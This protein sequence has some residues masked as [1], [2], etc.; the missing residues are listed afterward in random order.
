MAVAFCPLRATFRALAALCPLQE[1]GGLELAPL[2]GEGDALCPLSRLC[3]VTGR[4]R[5]VTGSITCAL[6]HLVLHVTC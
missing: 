3:G 4:G 1:V 6:A 2:V 5:A